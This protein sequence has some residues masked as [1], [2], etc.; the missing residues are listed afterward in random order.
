M[1]GDPAVALEQSGLFDLESRLSGLTSSLVVAGML[2]EL[3][4]LQAPFL[5]DLIFDGVCAVFHIVVNGTCELLATIGPQCRPLEP[6]DLLLVFD[7][8]AAQYSLAAPNRG[9]AQEAPSTAQLIAGAFRLPNPGRRSIVSLMP[10]VIHLRASDH[11]WLVPVRQMLADSV[12]RAP[13]SHAL[14]QHLLEGLFVQ[15]LRH[16]LPDTLTHGLAVAMR[17]RALASA[18]RLLHD[19]PQE[20]WTVDTLARRVGMSRS[21][22]AEH[23][24]RLLGISPMHYLARVRMQV[25]AQA[26]QAEPETKLAELASRVGYGSES[27]LI[28]AFRRHFGHAPRSHVADESQSHASTSLALAVRPNSGAADNEHGAW[29]SGLRQMRT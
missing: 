12:M 2:G 25:A 3:L 8:D 6:G 28:K 13:G 23:F 15:I 7:R 14:L 1:N 29:D 18:L 21:A 24:T 19:A 10:P 26:L 5:Q 9:D 4:T 11:P 17:D 16:A 20:P 22:F 27:A